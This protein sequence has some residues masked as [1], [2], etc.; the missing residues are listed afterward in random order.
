MA[1]TF[2]EGK[3]SINSR[4]DYTGFGQLSI[5]QCSDDFSYGT[6]AVLIAHHMSERINHPTIKMKKAF[7]EAIPRVLDM[8]CG[9][10]AI[11]F[12]LTHKCPKC[13]IVGVD[14]RKEALYLANMSLEYNHL[15]K[16][17][18]FLQHNI[19]K[20]EEISDIL[21]QEGHFDYIVSNPPYF[22]CRCSLAARDCNKRIARHGV[23][24]NTN[25]AFL[26]AAS[27]LLRFE[28]IAG[29]ITR[30]ENLSE[31]LEA[32]YKY[33]LGLSYMRLIANSIENR[34]KLMILEFVKG[35]RPQLHVDSLLYIRDK[36]GNYTDHMKKVYETF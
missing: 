1:D 28:G 2:Q 27:Q 18:H 14:V 15:Q 24:E 6:D 32:A 3:S 23:E 25:E 13:S 12:I 30:P 8:G 4:L 20:K 36:S 29:F 26:R 21:E 10:G 34:P 35:K 7:R 9:N 16:R 11:G 22:S 17:I 5:Y 33:K 31:M 19:S